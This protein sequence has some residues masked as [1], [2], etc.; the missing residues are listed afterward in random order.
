MS[1]SKVKQTAKKVI[2]KVVDAGKSLALKEVA[3]AQ[4]ALEIASAKLTAAKAIVDEKKA[5]LA[6]AKA[7][8][9]G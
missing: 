7:K 2:K 1:D 5:I 3:K 9:K 6:A 4:K 8:L